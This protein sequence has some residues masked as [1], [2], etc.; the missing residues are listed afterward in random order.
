MTT[1]DP[2]EYSISCEMCDVD[3]E[4]LVYDIDEI[5]LFCPMCGAEIDARG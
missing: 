4:I 3:T 5:P 1:R 2:Q